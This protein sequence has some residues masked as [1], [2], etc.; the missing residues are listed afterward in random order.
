MK[1]LVKYLNEKQAG[2]VVYGVFFNDDTMY[3]FYYTSD[4]AQQIVDKLNAED[5]HNKCK[6]V[7]MPKTDIEQ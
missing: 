4:D 6:I 3:N 2:D 7:T 1:D 5:S